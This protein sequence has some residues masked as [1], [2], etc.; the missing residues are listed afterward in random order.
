MSGQKKVK[1]LIV[2]LPLFAQQLKKDLEAFDRVNKYYCLDTYYNRKDRIKA[3]FRLPFVDVVYSINGSLSK[4]KVFD[5]AFLLK[6]RVMMTWVGTDVTKAKKESNKN[7]Q[8]LEYS[9]HYCEVEWI[10]QELKELKINA[11]IQNFFNFKSTIEAPIVTK[12]TLTILT[13]ISKNREE[14]Y[15][16]NELC[17]VAEQHPDVSFTVVGTDGVGKY[18]SN[19]HCL[20]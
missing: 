9:E 18:P 15:G 19:V 13:Y 10:Q 5:I 8:Y 7:Q 6:K 3:F 4:S 14:Y 2:G 11:K 1:V 20:G 16:W 17:F 12:P